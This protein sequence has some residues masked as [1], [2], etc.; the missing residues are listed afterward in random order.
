MYLKL[1]HGSILTTGTIEVF[2]NKAS[3]NYDETLQNIQQITFSRCDKSPKTDTRTTTIC[4]EIS[5]SSHDLFKHQTDKIRM[6][7][8]V[9]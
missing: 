1:W 8:C 9:D 6:C 4:D 7:V 5:I 2:L 3:P